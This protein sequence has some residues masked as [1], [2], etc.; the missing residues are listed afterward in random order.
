MRIVVTAASSSLGEAV[1]RRT[2]ELG[3]QVLPTDR[4]LGVCGDLKIV[5]CALSHPGDEEEE[6]GGQL[7]VDELLAGADYLIHLE[8]IAARGGA[9]LDR[10]TRCTYNLLG[11]AAAGGLQRVAVASTMGLLEAY[12]EALTVLPEFQPMPSTQPELLGPHLAEFTA[13]E[14]ARNTDLGISVVRLGGEHKPQSS[15]HRWCQTTE[16][17]AAALVDAVLEPH[18]NDGV[19]FTELQDDAF[20]RFKVRAL[21]RCRAAKYLLLDL[22][23]GKVF[24]PYD[25]FGT[26]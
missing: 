7:S 15:D 13:R 22:L 17:A 23:A 18:P 1:V 20:G 21:E 12:D 4:A 3:H 8:P 19:D 16:Q 26:N 10:C 5:G 11:A 2:L 25:M 9:W 14:F 6:G 24:T